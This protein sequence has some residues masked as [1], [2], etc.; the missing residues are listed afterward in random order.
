MGSISWQS[1]IDSFLSS[2]LGM[3]VSG[4]MSAVAV[5]FVILGVGHAVIKLHQQ[6]AG[7]VIRRILE[8]I[9]LGVIMITPKIWGTIAGLLASLIQAVATY[10]AN[11]VH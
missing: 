1:S 2:P 8:I 11:L 10:A 7:K 5:I 9:T 6:G 3:T 4:I